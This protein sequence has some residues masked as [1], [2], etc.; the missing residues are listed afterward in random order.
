[1][2]SSKPKIAFVVSRFPFPL[3]KGDKLRAYYQIAELAK[4]CEVSVHAIHKQDISGKQIEAIEKL[5]VRLFTYKLNS[6]LVLT[7]VFMQFFTRKPFQVGYFFQ[8]RLKRQLHR[9]VRVFSPDHIVCQLIRASEYVKD[10][11]EF[12]KTLDYMDALS[13]GMERR[14]GK[15]GFLKNFFIKWEYRK[16]KDYE[17]AI[18]HY[19]DHHT[20]ISEQDKACIYHRN[21][22]DIVV[23]KNG[24]DTGFFTTKNHEKKYEIGFVGNLSYPPNVLASQRLASKILPLLHSKGLN[25]KLVLSGA[26]PSKEVLKL[27]NE[28]I[29]ITGWVDDIRDSYDNIKVFVAPLEIGTGLQ[30][31]LLEAMSMNVPCVTT[32]LVNNALKAQD[33]NHLVLADSDEEIAEKILKILHDKEFYE[34]LSGNARSFVQDNYNWSATTNQLLKLIKS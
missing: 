16:L 5:G 18:F 29:D 21:Q 13:K 23:I 20:I 31:K 34:K 8:R 9:D 25:C 1:M 32:T 4:K 10:L 27:R 14:I 24:I 33:G 26:S 30:N 3:E 17:N 2:N 22:S 11:H 12:P 19:F 15:E 7:Q 6:L 28:F